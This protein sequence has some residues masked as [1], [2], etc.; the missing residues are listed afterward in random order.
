MS[1]PVNNS[2]AATPNT[3][4]P[5]TAAT[6]NTGT[7]APIS[8]TPT[9]IRKLKLKLDTGEVEMP[10]SE[11]IA[12]AQKAKVADKRFQ[13]AAAQRKE[14]EQLFEFFKSDPKAAMKKLGID[15]REFSENFLMEAI[16]QEAMSPEQRRAAENEQ[17]LR[18]YQTKE[19]EVKKKAER[20]ELLKL[21]STEMVRL[22]NLFVEALKSSGLP[23]TN[24]TVKRM[25]ELTMVA[26][27]NGWTLDPQSL[28]KLVHEDLINEQKAL[29]SSMDGDSLLS[30]LGAEGTK[31]FNK[32]TLAKLKSAAPK[33]SNPAPA[34]ATKSN[35]EQKLTWKQLQQKNR[36]LTY[37]S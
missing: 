8:A 34:A 20:E 7:A 22:D 4:N 33:F 13:E 26:N 30:M 2:A 18:E 14:A 23:K 27:R 16:K 15:P 31:K 28:A 3:V 29:F 17:K 1:N 37:G 21:E 32:A 12:W 35:S 10:E 24:Y 19:S 6:P 36:R 11:V 25:A 9:E 5:A